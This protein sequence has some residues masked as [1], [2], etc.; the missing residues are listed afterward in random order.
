MAGRNPSIKDKDMEQQIY[1]RLM[2]TKKAEA[3]GIYVTEEAAAADANQIL[4]S[5]GRNGQSVPI[6]S[7]VQQVLTPEGLTAD[8]LSVLPA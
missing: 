3:L 2:L 7:F 8:D 4:R 1:L 5:V 6:E